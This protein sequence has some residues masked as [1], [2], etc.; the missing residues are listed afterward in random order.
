[1]ESKFKRGDVIAEKNWI[2]RTTQFV[3]LDTVLPNWI[4]LFSSSGYCAT[5]S[6]EQEHYY[7]KIGEVDLKPL[8][9]EIKQ[10]KLRK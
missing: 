3:V 7:T 2:G 9:E 1:M 8:C 5:L 6:R 4:Y 10:V